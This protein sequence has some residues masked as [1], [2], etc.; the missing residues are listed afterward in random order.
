MS[1]TLHN[2]IADHFLVD[3]RHIHKLQSNDGLTKVLVSSAAYAIVLE[4]AWNE[5]EET[6]TGLPIWLLYE[7]SKS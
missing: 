2:S 1:A 4:L 5:L 6:P 7:A 3:Q